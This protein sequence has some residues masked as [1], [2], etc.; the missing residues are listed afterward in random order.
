MKLPDLK[1][2]AGV[3]GTYLREYGETFGI[4]LLITTGILA[5]IN[6]LG[7]LE[8]TQDVKRAIGAL[9]LAYTL[10]GAVIVVNKAVKYQLSLK[11]GQK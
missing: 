7:F 10:V 11:K 8:L 4:A 6:L 2:K 9:V 1:T 3:A 5:S